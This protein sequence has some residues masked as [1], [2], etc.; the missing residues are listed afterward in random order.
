MSIYASGTYELSDSYL[1]FRKERHIWNGLSA[2]D[3]QKALAKF[4]SSEIGG[5]KPYT[6]TSAVR[7]AGRPTTHE[8]ALRT[9]DNK[10]GVSGVTSK[11]SVSHD[12]VKLVGISENVLEEIWVKSE[13]LL[14]EPD[15]VVKVPGCDGYFI[16]HSLGKKLQPHLVIVG[17]KGKV[18]CD[19]CVTYK[20]LKLCLHA[21]CVAETIGIL[22]KYLD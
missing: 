14:L 12:T 22:D 4:W 6:G 13:G 1:A 19:D 21:L 9:E 2:H 7:I 20:G 8:E 3:R 15:L 10:G 16:R 11:L 5:E 17:L 18:T